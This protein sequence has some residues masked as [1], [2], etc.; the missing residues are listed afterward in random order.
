MSPPR[1]YS[2]QADADLEAMRQHSNRLVALLDGDSIPSDLPVTLARR[3][4]SRMRRSGL[5][6]ISEL[7]ELWPNGAWSSCGVGGGGSSLASTAALR[8]RRAPSLQLRLLSTHMPLKPWRLGVGTCTPI[9]REFLL[10]VLTPVAAL[11]EWRGTPGDGGTRGIR[12]D[13]TRRDFTRG[14]HQKTWGA[15]LQ[16]LAFNDSTHPLSEDSNDMAPAWLKVVMGRKR[17]RRQ[18]N[19]E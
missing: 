8:V 16:P 1:L 13:L 6:V 19:V 9:S 15:P 12:S 14:G 5:P 17:N 18:A 2:A 11:G 3:R 4:R 7:P 10:L